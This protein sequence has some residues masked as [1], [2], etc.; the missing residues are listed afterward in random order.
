MK[1]AVT[2]CRVSG[3]HR[4]GDKLGAILV[5]GLEE[6]LAVVRGRAGGV[7]REH[8][9]GIE[10]DAVGTAAKTVQRLHDHDRVAQV[11]AVGDILH[12]GE[13]RPIDA[14]SVKVGGFAWFPPYSAGGVW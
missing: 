8:L 4:D 12:I 9:G 6:K 11:N 13:A 7:W 5:A 1:G 14:G 10:H 2:V 3:L